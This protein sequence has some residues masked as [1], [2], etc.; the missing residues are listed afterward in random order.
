MGTGEDTSPLFA[1]M[2]GAIHTKHSLGNLVGFFK[3]PLILT[4]TRLYGNAIAQFWWL[5]RTLEARLAATSSDP[6]VEHAVASIG[7]GPLAPGY[8]G[9]LRQIL[10]PDWRAAAE[11]CL[12]PATRSYAAALE[13]ADATA[14]VGALFILYGALVIGGGKQT[15]AKVRRVFPACDHALFDVAGDMRDA[16]RRFKNT[17]T[18]VG[19]DHAGTPAV[20]PDRAD[21]LVAHAAHWMRRNN[22]VVLS[23][24]V[25]PYWWWKAAALAAAATLV[26]RR[27][28][29]S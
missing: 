27:L 19:R 3:L 25:L 2:M 12:T 17:F 1:R 20:A 18:A 7:V 28:R 21:A 8:E 11:R 4:D 22:E 14:L 10:G 9:D 23:V 16:R 15:Q 26:A 29:S 24:R 5:T 6:L 13:R